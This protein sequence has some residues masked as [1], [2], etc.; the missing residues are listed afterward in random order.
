[1]SAGDAHAARPGLT[2]ELLEL[3]VELRD[4]A[5]DER[6]YERSDRIRDALASAGIELRD[7]PDGSHLRPV[8]RGARAAS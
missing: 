7:G 6:D 4:R 1:L 8:D 3:L 2:D 5:R